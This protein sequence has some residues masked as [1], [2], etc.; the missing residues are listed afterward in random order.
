[1]RYT[2]GDE[3]GRVG[4]SVE[5]LQRC[6]SAQAHEADTSM[7]PGAEIMVRFHAAFK[8]VFAIHDKSV[9]GHQCVIDQG[10]KSDQPYHFR[11]HH[12]LE[13]FLFLLR[14]FLHK[15]D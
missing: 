11:I 2:D 5:P 9:K 13:H 8:W 6:K 4:P 10:S 1:M 7:T 14:R 3:Y 12:A 15:E